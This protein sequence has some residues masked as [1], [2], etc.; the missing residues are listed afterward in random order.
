MELMKTVLPTV[1]LALTFAASAETGTFSPSAQSEYRDNAVSRGMTPGGGFNDKRVR[2]A[3]IQERTRSDNSEPFEGERRI[4]GNTVRRVVLAATTSGIRL[5][6]QHEVGK[7][8]QG[9]GLSNSAGRQNE[10]GASC[11]ECPE[12]IPV[13]GHKFAIGKY[14]VTFKEWDACVAAGGC[15]AY[16]PSDNGWGRGNRPVINVS[17]EDA[18]AYIQWIS[19]K[20]GKTYR[21]PTKDEWEIA[22]LA[23]STTDYYW[24]NDVGRNNANCDGCGSEWDNRRTAPVGS[25]K[26]NAFGIYDMMGNVW[27]W[28]DTCW[29]GNCTKRM[30]F[31]GSWNHRPQDMR[32]IT[33]NWFNTNKRMRYLGFRLAMTLP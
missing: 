6:S 24:G 15:G 26:P 2:I 4:D 10:D 1:L 31:G 11:P 16:Q 23:G 32:A 27:Q 5:V 20:T 8:R 18:Q 9:S 13:P 17:W 33:R 29:Q 22:A 7:Q 3:E 25:F 19:E 12:M 21:L 30:F 14:T 28:T